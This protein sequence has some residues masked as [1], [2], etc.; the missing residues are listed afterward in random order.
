MQ[1]G[2]AIVRNRVYV[3]A[4]IDQSAEYRLS[5]F[6][7]LI[8]P[9]QGRVAVFASRVG[10]RA[11]SQ[12]L[13]HSGGVRVLE[14]FPGVPVSAIPRIGE[15]GAEIR[16][17]QQREDGNTGDSTNAVM[18]GLGGIHDK[19]VLSALIRWQLSADSRHR[20]PE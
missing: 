15:G 10:V 6:A 17:D 8:R 4:G 14:E 9:M 20:F 12:A 16:K 13:A 5:V 7:A 11:G 1:R 19:P 3:G 18:P 2:A